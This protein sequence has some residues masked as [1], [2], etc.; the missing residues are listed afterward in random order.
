MD[1]EANNKP[2]K[3]IQE[4][5]SGQTNKGTL[6]QL[7]FRCKIIFMICCELILRFCPL[8]GPRWILKA[9]LN[10]HAATIKFC[11]LF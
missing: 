11:Y 5:M 10:H 9:T 4:D 1:L 6:M 8:K 7:I 2:A 3:E